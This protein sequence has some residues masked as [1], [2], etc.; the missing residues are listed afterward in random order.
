MGAS[1]SGTCSTGQSSVYH[2]TSRPGGRC[3][4]PRRPIGVLVASARPHKGQVVRPASEAA[5]SSSS[6]NQEASRRSGNH[7]RSAHATSAP[8]HTGVCA[9]GRK[10]TAGAHSTELAA[11][12]PGPP[13]SAVRRLVRAMVCPSSLPADAEVGRVV[14]VGREVVDAMVHLPQVVGDLGVC[15]AA[16]VVARQRDRCPPRPLNPVGHEHRPGRAQQPRKRS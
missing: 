11:R 13:R 16:G 8:A 9:V 4:S 3:R 10:V 6:P 14:V 15:S 2:R 12:A 1:V 5:V 7:P